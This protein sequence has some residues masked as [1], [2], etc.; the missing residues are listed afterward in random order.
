MLLHLWSGRKQHYLRHAQ[1]L[2][3]GQLHKSNCYWVQKLNYCVI[4]TLVPRHI[5]PQTQL[6]S[7]IFRNKV[8]QAL[9]CVVRHWFEMRWKVLILAYRMV[10]QKSNS[11]HLGLTPLHLKWCTSIQ[12]HVALG[13]FCDWIFLK[14]RS[15]CVH[16]LFFGPSRWR[17]T[18]CSETRFV[19]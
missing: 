11:D 4:S 5:L 10:G 1:L 16:K 17:S 13:R 19:A 9:K 14:M 15:K 6:F 3:N 2:P 7:L 8:F 12:R 18:F